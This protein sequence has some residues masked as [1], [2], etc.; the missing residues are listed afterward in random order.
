VSPPAPLSVPPGALRLPTFTSSAY[1]L[2][3]HISGA[4]HTSFCSWSS[5]R[6]RTPNRGSWAM[7]T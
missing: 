2:A 7:I 1:H 6:V 5:R 3:P 4:R